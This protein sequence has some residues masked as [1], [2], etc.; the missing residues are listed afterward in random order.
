MY[1]EIKVMKRGKM[2]VKQEND[3]AQLHS[4]SIKQFLL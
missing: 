4:L 1:F 2:F 3:Q